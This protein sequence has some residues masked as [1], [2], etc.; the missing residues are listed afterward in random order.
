MVI[1]LP[2]ELDVFSTAF[3]VVLGAILGFVGTLLIELAKRRWDDKDQKEYSQKL[4]IAL[5][6][7]IEEGIGR[8]K[9]LIEAS[10]NG[11]GSF[12][13]IYIGL[14]DSSRLKISEIVEDEE[15]LELL[16]K[17]YYRFDLI[18]FNMERDRFLPGAAFA[19]DYINEIESNYQ[20]LKEIIDP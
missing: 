4:L 12:S 1:L 18:N 10:K 14:W 7:E 9:W 3:G 11:K 15:I 8:S 17:I 19:R 6:K 5:C 2:E 16:H 20:K 13:R